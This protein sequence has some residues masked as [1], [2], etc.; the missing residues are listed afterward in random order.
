M[1]VYQVVATD[2]DDPVAVE[3]AKVVSVILDYYEQYSEYMVQFEREAIAETI[4]NQGS[5]SAD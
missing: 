1:S 2:P 4:R 3:A 5:E